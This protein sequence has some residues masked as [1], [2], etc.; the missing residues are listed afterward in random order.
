MHHL[1]LNGRIS[2]RASRDFPALVFLFGGY[3]EWFNVIVT[4]CVRIQLRTCIFSICLCDTRRHDRCLIVYFFS[5]L[6]YCFLDFFGVLFFF[7][8]SLSVRFSV[9]VQIGIKR[10]S[11]T[12]LKGWEQVELKQTHF[13]ISIACGTDSNLS[14]WVSRQLYFGTSVLA[15]VT[16]S[17]SSKQCL[18]VSVLYVLK[19]SAIVISEKRLLPRESCLP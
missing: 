6:C 15:S 13:D 14:K 10:R 12:P 7:L 19:C 3:E 17:L 16:R 11:A 1:G 4:Q 8:C 18:L 2:W 5:L 9:V